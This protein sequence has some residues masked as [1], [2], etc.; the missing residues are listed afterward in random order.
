M[1]K[2][3]PFAGVYFCGGLVK[4]FLFVKYFLLLSIAKYRY[5]ASLLL[6]SYCVFLHR[7]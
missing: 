1:E 3:V 4:L 7:L 5:P 2:G 6:K